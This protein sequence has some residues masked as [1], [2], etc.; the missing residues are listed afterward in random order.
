MSAAFTL[1]PKYYVPN[2]VSDGGTVVALGAG[3]SK[4]QGGWYSASGWPQGGAVWTPQNGLMKLNGGPAWSVSADGKVV[5]GGSH[6]GGEVGAYRWTSATGV[7]PL[8]GGV[9]IATRVSADGSVIVGTIGGANYSDSHGVRWVNGGAPQSLGQ[10]FIPTGVSR[11]GSTVVGIGGYSSNK[12]VIWTATGGTGKLADP[13]GGVYAGAFGISSDGKTIYGSAF[14]GPA[15]GLFDLARWTGTNNVSAVLPPRDL[16]PYGYA[17]YADAAAP[18]FLDVTRDGKIVV[19]TRQFSYGGGPENEAFIWDPNH[20]VRSLVDALSA[21]F[22]LK[23]ALKGW[24]VEFAHISD[25]GSAIVGS[26]WGPNGFQ[27]FL[28]TLSDSG[29]PV[30][31]PTTFA[32]GLV[33]VA[34]GLAAR[35][36]ARTC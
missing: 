17:Q 3:S 33:A 4:E 22:G 20:G 5:V 35:T 18:G 15:G 1:L 32:I 31:E 9:G 6:Y 30:P 34:M 25:D 7:T 26:G 19:G 23:D 2:A 21:D 24:N 29:T 12:P 13:S 8:P 14:G 11:D 10:Y 16:G 28:V 36:R 27:G